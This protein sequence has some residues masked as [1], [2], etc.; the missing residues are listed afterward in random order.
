MPAALRLELSPSRYLG[1]FLVVVYGLGLST[2]PLLPG[3][4]LPAL[5]TLLAYGFWM[6]HQWRRMACVL[7]FAREGWFLDGE[8]A[9]PVRAT[10]WPW[11]ISLSLRC[12]GRLGTRHL[13]ILGDSCSAG[14]HRCLRGVLRHL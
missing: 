5:L 11:L 1:C 10:V 4:Y 6:Y 12:P 9:V 14:D 2:L 13:L 3:W 7:E 8:P